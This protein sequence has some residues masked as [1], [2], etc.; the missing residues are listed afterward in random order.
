MR[1]SDHQTTENNDTLLKSPLTR[2]DKS[3]IESALWVNNNRK[4]LAINNLIGTYRE[5]NFWRILQYV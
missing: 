5:Y 3:R 1:S 4:L 2:L